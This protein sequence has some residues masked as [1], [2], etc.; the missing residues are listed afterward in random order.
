MAGNDRVW[1]HLGWFSGLICAGSVVGTAAWVVSIQQNNFYFQSMFQSQGY[2]SRQHYVLDASSFRFNAIFLA[3]YP[4]EFLCLIVP[5]L[6]LLGRLADNAIRSQVHAP[7]VKGRIKRLLDRVFRSIAAVVVIC[8]VGCM[9]AWDVAAVNNVE[10][11]QLYDQAADACDAQGN[12]TNASLAIFSQVANG[13]Y[14]TANTAVSVQNMLEAVALLI[15]SLAYLVLV[16]LSIALFRRAENQSS[17]VLLDMEKQ[18]ENSVVQLPADYAAPGYQGAPDALIELKKGEAKT[19]M[20]LTQAAAASQRRRFVAACVIVQVTF[21]ARVAF[22]VLQA[23]S[24]FDNPMNPACGACDP[25]QTDRFLIETWLGYTPEFQPIVVCLSSPLP[26]A[27][28]LWLM[29]TTEERAQLL[30]P[31]DGFGWENSEMEKALAARQRM[32]IDL[33]RT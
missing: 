4:V 20:E 26:L 28:S 31:N 30:H 2:T 22:D 21:F 23:Y 9:V 18:A 16:P 33:N 5:K 15:I 13:N 19:V 6:M 17:S 10:S 27:I 29:M 1:R 25:C 7:D 24:S 11:A 8:S 14:I 32:G 12:D 3:L